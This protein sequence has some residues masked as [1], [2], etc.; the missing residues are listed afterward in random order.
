MLEYFARHAT[1]CKAMSN[2]EVST[3]VLLPGMDGTGTLFTRFVRALPKSLDSKIIAYPAR[4]PLDY[5]QLLDLVWSQL[6]TDRSY[7][8]LAES[9]SGPL[10][11]ELAARRPPGFAKL[12]LCCTFARNPRP[13]LNAFA[14][15][16]PVLPLRKSP[17]GLIGRVLMGRSFQ[18]ELQADFLEAMSR[19]TPETIRG[20]ARAVLDVDV[21]ARLQAIDIPVLYLQASQDLVVPPTAAALITA[22]KPEVELVVL[23]APHFLLQTRPAEAAH[24][25]GNFLASDAKGR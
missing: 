6:P 13:S 2:A 15:L 8:L 16:L 22:A 3:L 19:L 23:P 24:L 11:I 17:L 14:R 20:R 21:L 18:R 1:H 12:V 9:F 7:A 10:G 5:A 4:T 25:V